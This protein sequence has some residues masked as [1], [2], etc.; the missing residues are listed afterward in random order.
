MSGSTG[1]AGVLAGWTRGPAKPFFCGNRYVGQCITVEVRR[2]S[3]NGR[4]PDLYPR[5]KLWLS[6]SEA[7]GVFG[8][9]I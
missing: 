4:T 7:E 8:D 2:M 9:G 1:M 3:G 5:F 6:S